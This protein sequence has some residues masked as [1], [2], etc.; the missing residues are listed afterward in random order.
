[1][2]HWSVRAV[3]SLTTVLKHAVVLEVF[4]DATTHATGDGKH[5]YSVTPLADGMDLTSAHASVVVAGTVG[6]TL[7]IQIYNM[8]KATDMLT[9]KITVDATEYHSLT[10][11]TPPVIDTAADDVNEGDVL[12]VDV[13]ALNTTPGQGLSIILEFTQP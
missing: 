1:M 6:A 4:A 13:D 11:L 9:T 5:Y 8:T 3:S 2:A 10:A 7:D 12:R